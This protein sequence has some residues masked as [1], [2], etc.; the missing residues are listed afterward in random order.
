MADAV[1][2]R[3]VAHGLKSN[4]ADFGAV[5]FSALCKELEA[6]GKSGTLEGAENLYSSIASEFELVARA[7]AAIREA[8][9]I[10]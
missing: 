2:V 10:G 8:G 7:L 4:G 1:G 9:K 5:K 6:V 3:R